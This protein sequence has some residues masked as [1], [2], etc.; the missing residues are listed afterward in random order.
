MKKQILIGAMCLFIFSSCAQKKEKSDMN[1]NENNEQ[2]K[3]YKS[4]PL[5]GLQVDKMGCRLSVIINDETLGDYFDKGGFSATETINGHIV[6]SGRQTLKLLVYPR[7]GS[8]FID[9][10]A[11]IKIEIIF[12]AQKG[13][14][15]ESYKVIKTVELPK[16]L[17]DKKL[18]YFELSIPFEAE[19]PWDY[20]DFYNNLIDLRKVPDIE[21]KV[22]HEYEN[23]RELI[24]N[25][26]QAKYLSFML[27]N[28]FIEYNTFYMTKEEIKESEEWIGKDATKLENKEVLPLR[29][30]ELV[31]EK[32]GKKAFLRDKDSRDGVIKIEYGSI[33]TDGDYKGQ[34]SKET[35]ISP[36][37][38]MVKGS[39][40]FESL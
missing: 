3:N 9:E 23:L 5:Y 32:D 29:N 19:V 2:V 4:Q 7:T 34:R 28:Q 35:A 27:K 14:S 37:L 39:T 22:I 13:D 16:D 10:L 12:A 20:S 15:M 30:Y 31:F 11:N 40:K 33:N 38:I 18:P 36:N 26:E 17:K 6:K 8:E 25:N 21:K 24:A 1:T